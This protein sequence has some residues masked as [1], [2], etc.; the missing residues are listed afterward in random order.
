MEIPIEVT[1]FKELKGYKA[2]I[3]QGLDITR[4]I[5]KYSLGKE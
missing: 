5:L 1:Y 4:A 2:T 3:K